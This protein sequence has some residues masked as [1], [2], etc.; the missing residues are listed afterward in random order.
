MQG[1]TPSMEIIRRYLEAHD[2]L[3]TPRTL[4]RDIASIRADLDVDIIYDSEKNGYFINTDSSLDLP[5]IL[6]FINLSESSDII[7]QSL[8]DKKDILQYL[9]ISP[10]TE[11]KGIEHL[12]TLLQAIRS[13]LVIQYQHLN[14]EKQTNKTYIAEPY[15]LK[16]FTG[17][18]YLFAYIREKGAFRT[19]GLDRISKLTLTNTRFERER[20]LAETASKFDNVFGLVYEP[21]QNINAPI[22]EV[23]LRFSQLMINHLSAL[24]LHKSQQINEDVV[25]LQIIINPEI[26]NKILSYGEHVEVL[27][28][29]SLREKIKERLA[30]TLKKYDQ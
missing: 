20:Q 21:E 29:Q 7:L 14:Y 25:N 15:L 27:S 17:R 2:C 19:F 3:I 28:P 22:E 30:E 13:N 16:E 9:S 24:P 12:G 4:Q 8:K 6:Y 18:W 1:D 26:E 11:F 23:Q 5:K 10:N